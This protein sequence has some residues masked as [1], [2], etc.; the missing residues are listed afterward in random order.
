MSRAFRRAVFVSISLPP[1]CIRRFLLLASIARIISFRGKVKISG[2]FLRYLIVGDAAFLVDFFILFISVEFFI[3]ERSGA[4]LYI[5]SALAFAAG[6]ILNYFLSFLLVFT[7]DRYG[8]R[9]NSPLSFFVFAA[10]A[11]AGLGLTETGMFLGVG[12]CNCNY[13][14]VKITVSLLALVWNYGIRRIFLLR[15]GKDKGEA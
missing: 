6:F 2:E 11:L 8:K 15:K 9:R 12:L 13:I 10:I 7:G 3:P 4:G 1:P 14:A 5:A